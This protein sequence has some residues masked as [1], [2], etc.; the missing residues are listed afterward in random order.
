MGLEVVINVAAPG[1]R[2]AWKWA[3]P[4]RRAS[5]ARILRPPQP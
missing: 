5:R 2:S 4:S 3:R 1:S